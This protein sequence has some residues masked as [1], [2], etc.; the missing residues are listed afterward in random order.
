MDNEYYVDKQNNDE[1]KV[2]ILDQ[3]LSVDKCC[4]YTIFHVLM[5]F[6]ALY[7]TFRCKR[8]GNTKLFFE[9]LFAIF[10]PYFYI[11]WILVNHGT[12]DIIS[13]E[14]HASTKV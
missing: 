10:C 3:N 2:V 6:F 9:V 14:F 12:C 4:I 11:M 8:Y 5:V 13:G 1:K 7:L